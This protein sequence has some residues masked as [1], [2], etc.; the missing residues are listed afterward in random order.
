MAENKE[1]MSQELAEKEFADWAEEMGLDIE[2]DSRSEDDNIVFANAKKLFIKAVIKGNGVVD[3]EGN[4]IYTVS[5][6]SPEGYKETAVK[7]GLPP[8]R[9]FVS[10]TKNDSNGMQRV[11]S[12]ASGMTGKDTGWILNLALLD[13]KFFM[14]IA[15]LFLL[16]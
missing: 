6:K 7:I 5:A 4:F 2:D 8:P 1:T 15:G 14:G 13:F 11:L 12:I 3:D 9:A 16:N 10:N